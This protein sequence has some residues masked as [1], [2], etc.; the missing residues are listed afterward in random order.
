M[1]ISFPRTLKTNIYQIEEDE[2]IRTL[3]IYYN[4]NI[5]DVWLCFGG[6]CG[7]P[8]ETFFGYSEGLGNPLI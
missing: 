8:V 7:Y 6:R 2:E 5:F 4:L 3:R 1:L